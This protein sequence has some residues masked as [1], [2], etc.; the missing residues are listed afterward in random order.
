MIEDLG[1]VSVQE[2][3]RKNPKTHA[4]LDG[5]GTTARR[6]VSTVGCFDFI[7][8]SHYWVFIG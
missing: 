7:C 3:S 6:H 4:L 1:V 8:V 2:K 5:T